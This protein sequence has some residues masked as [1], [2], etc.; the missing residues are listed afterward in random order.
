MSGPHLRSIALL[1]MHW[2][3]SSE[4]DRDHPPSATGATTDS[5]P[6]GEHR[7]TGR[8]FRKGFKIP[9][10]IQSLTLKSLESLPTFVRDSVSDGPSRAR[11]SRS[12]ALTGL[13]PH[14]KTPGRHPNRHPHALPNPRSGMDAFSVT[15][16]VLFALVSPVLVGSF[17]KG[18][19]SL[20]WQ[21][22]PGE[23]CS[24][25]LYLYRL[26]EH[27]SR[28][29]SRNSVPVHP[30]GTA[31]WESVLHQCPGT[32]GRNSVPEQCSFASGLTA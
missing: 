9:F 25:S 12:P 28:T 29:G 24:V 18:P 15:R 8:R 23:H 16:C 10:R 31:S 5:R 3:P 19:A 1:H 22:A 13:V 32:G 11:G 14:G 6:W 26:P 27:C 30:S 20:Q 2:L 7:S 4:A 21:I 17:S